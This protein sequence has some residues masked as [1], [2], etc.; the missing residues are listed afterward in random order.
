GGVR[1]GA[2][3]LESDRPRQ[4]FSSSASLDRSGVVRGRRAVFSDFLR[5]RRHPHRS[6]W[7]RAF[8]TRDLGRVCR[9]RLRRIH[10]L[11][12][13][14]LARGA[15]LEE[16]GGL[17]HRFRLDLA[18]RSGFTDRIPVRRIRQFVRAGENENPTRGRWLW[19]RTIGSTIFGEGVDSLIFYPLA[20]YGS[21]LIPDDRLPQIMLVQLVSKVELEVAFRPLTYAVVGW[22]KRAE[23]EDY[24]DRDTDFSPFSLKI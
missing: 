5:V 3:L 18:H 13:G 12:R 2:D 14:R 1:H 19:T 22:L 20:F 4:D 10:G 23:Q 16:P 6:L 9:S 15:F 17:R 24:Y 8:P 21:G 11:D 7:L